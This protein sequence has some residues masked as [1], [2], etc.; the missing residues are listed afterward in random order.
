MVTQAQS[1][2]VINHDLFY[3]L[4]RERKKIKI[5]V[6]RML[7][8]HT[9]MHHDQVQ[10]KKIFAYYITFSW[11]TN[12]WSFCWFITS[13]DLKLF[14]SYNLWIYGGVILI[15]SKCSCVF[16]LHEIIL[17]AS[18]SPSLRKK[19]LHLGRWNNCSFR[20]KIVMSKDVCL[21]Y[22]HIS[23]MIIFILIG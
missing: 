8:K 14:S 19:Y 23:F 2:L 10:E 9:C 5:F 11:T 15:I 12:S 22:Q 6:K 3:F 17:F 20:Q 7:Q 16:H 21:R 4:I 13:N 1:E 18:S